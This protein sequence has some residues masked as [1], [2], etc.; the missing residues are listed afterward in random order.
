[1]ASHGSFGGSICGRIFSVA[2]AVMLVLTSLAC[3]RSVPAAKAAERLDDWNVIGPGGGGTQLDPA[4]SPVNPDTVFVRCDMTGNYLSHD[5]GKS[6]RMFNLRTSGRCFFDPQDA[7][8]LYVVAQGLYRSADGGET[9]NLITP[10][11][12]DVEGVV[13]NGDHGEWRYAL[14]GGTASTRIESLAV[15]PA[16]SK[17]LYA[18]AASTGGRRL[19]VSDNTGAR[20]MD[21]GKLPADAE[22]IYIDPRSPSNGRTLYVAGPSGVSMRKNG[23]WTQFKLPDGV[24]RFQHITAA[25]PKVGRMVFY[26]STAMTWQGEKL[27]G[28]IYASRDGGETWAAVN[29]DDFAK[30]AQKPG[31]RPP[32]IRAIAAC[33]TAPDVLYVSYNN[34]G[35]F[36]GVARSTDGGKSFDLAVKNT[37][38]KAAAN[39]LDAY[40]DGYWGPDWGEAPIALAVAPTDPDIC[41]GTDYGRTMRTTDG[42]KTWVGVYSTKQGQGWTSTGLDVTTCYGVHRDPFNPKRLFISYTD[43]GMWHSEDGGASWIHTTEKEG[44]VREWRNTT[45]WVSFD[46]QV[47]GVCWAAAAG[48][49]DLPRPK[50]WRRSGGSAGS[51]GPGPV[52][53][54]GGVLRS[55][56]GGKTWKGVEGMTSTAVTHVIPDPKSPASARVVYAAG[57][58]TGIWKSSDGGKTWALK[59][60]GIASKYPF[61]WRLAFDGKSALYAILARRSEDGSFGNELDGF[62][63]R[64][65]D[66]AESWEQVKLPEGVNGPNGILIDPKDASRIYLACWGRGSR[67][68]QASTGGTNGGVFL[69]TDAGKTW[70]NIF[71]KNQYVYD[72][73]MDPKDNSVL[74]ACGFESSAWRSGDKGRT[75]QRLDGYDFKWGHRVVPDLVYPNKLFITTFG[76]SV[77]YG[78]VKGDSDAK[79]DIVTPQASYQKLGK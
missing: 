24:T 25:M 3:T 10:S 36:F 75:W 39:E 46:P 70:K 48:N 5:G 77:W 62:V 63:Y 57:F 29:L 44:M 7:K 56:D 33:M 45:Y 72:V 2:A 76:G 31:N 60:N 13:V 47:K 23:G 8:V 17:T 52:N 12:E 26:G 51:A 19:L 15:D 42:L 20:W 21:G 43:I 32:A 1:M 28:G 22:Q 69:S 41:Y 40:I 6:W 68:D 78:P 59:N 30:V 55:V 58:G 14:D 18:I 65:T 66:G 9:W 50:M 35:G 49:H 71:D 27:V 53:F 61:A 79:D 37:S 67:N 74:Y 38:G 54:R 73:T 16:D 34:L 64:S 4:I 11:A